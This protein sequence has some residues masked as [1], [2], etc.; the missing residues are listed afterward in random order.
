LTSIGSFQ[1]SIIWIKKRLDFPVLPKPLSSLVNQRVQIHKLSFI[2]LKHILITSIV[3]ILWFSNAF[4]QT[5]YD[6]SGRQI[7]RV[8]GERYYDSSGR[9]IGR[10]D[11]N[12][13]YDSSGRQLGRIEGERIY[14]SSGSQIGRIDAERLYSSS[15]TQM[16]RIDGDRIYDGSGRQIGRADGLRRMQIIVFF[17]FF[18]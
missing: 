2:Q 8:D 12:H 5:L 6:G 16:G 11:G 18:M 13:I 3:F 15:G 10:V 17:Y 9:Q 4:A 1:N 14:N 7:G